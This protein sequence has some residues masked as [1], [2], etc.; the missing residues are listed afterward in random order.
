MKVSSVR[1]DG[2]FYKSYPFGLLRYHLRRLRGNGTSCSSHQNKAVYLLRNRQAR[3][4]F[5]PWLS[6]VFSKLGP[7]DLMLDATDIALGLVVANI[8][9]LIGNYGVITVVATKQ[10][11]ADD[12]LAKAG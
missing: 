7:V 8:S 2:M 10:G 6:E 5:I 11:S 1:H 3:T 4:N 12:L 9:K